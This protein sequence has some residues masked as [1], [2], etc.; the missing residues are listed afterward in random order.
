MSEPL[1]MVFKNKVLRREN[2]VIFLGIC[3]AQ[4]KGGAPYSQFSSPP[5]VD[6]LSK[7]VRGTNPDWKQRKQSFTHLN[8]VLFW[9]D[10]ILI[11]NVRIFNYFPF[12]E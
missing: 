8:T 4:A 1:L 11:P 3:G 5:L 9:S 12:E 10:K 7:S 2:V 6:P